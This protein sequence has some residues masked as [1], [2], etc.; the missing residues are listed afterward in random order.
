MG[1]EFSSVKIEKSQYQMIQELSEKTGHQ[2]GFHLARAI[3]N[4]LSDEGPEWLR[5]VAGVQASRRKK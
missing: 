5:A 2:V 4:Y 1:K 3:A